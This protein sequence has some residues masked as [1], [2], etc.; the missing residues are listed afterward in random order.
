MLFNKWLS[1]YL[2]IYVLYQNAIEFPKEKNAIEFVFSAKF[3]YDKGIVVLYM[4]V[5]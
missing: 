1:F 2:F 4:N 3:N 5:I